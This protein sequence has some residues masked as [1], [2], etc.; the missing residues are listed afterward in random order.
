MSKKKTVYFKRNKYRSEEFSVNDLP[1]TRRHQFFDILKNDWKTLLLIGLIL[2]VVSI[3]YLTIDVIHWFI[4][5]NLP[6]QLANDGGTPEMIASGLR[7]TEILYETAL[8]PATILLAVP[9]AGIARVLKRLIHGEGVLFKDDFFEGVKMNV[10]QFLV[11]T[12]IYSVLRFLTQFTHIFTQGVPIMSEIVYGVSIGILHVLFVP[13]ILFMFSEASIYK[14]KFWMNFKNS[15]QL[16]MHSIL[17]MLIFSF[18]LFGVYFMRYINHPILRIGL[19]VLL[20]MLSPLYLLSLSLF[21][22]S[23]F[24]IFINKDNYQEIYRKGLRPLEVKED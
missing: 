4:K 6:I 20:I 16:T 10:L 23:K 3:P 8:I 1:L 17:V 9:L 11:L 13:I 12:L 2:L 5:T 14:I 22:M 21:T 7:L 18:V 15:Y 24:D 19:D